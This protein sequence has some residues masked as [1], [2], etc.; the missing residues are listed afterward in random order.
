MGEAKGLIVEFLSDIVEAEILAVKWVRHALH[1]RELETC[2]AQPC[3]SSIAAAVLP[4][5][6][7]ALVR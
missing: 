4:L 3:S 2:Q 1:A 7:P 5:H 6:V